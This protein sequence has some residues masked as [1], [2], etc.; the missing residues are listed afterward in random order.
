MKSLILINS[1]QIKKLAIISFLIFVIL[2]I[3]ESIELI[4]DLID[5][6]IIVPMF[7]FAIL[8]GVAEL[9]LW[10]IG[11]NLGETNIV[12]FIF[13][14]IWLGAFISLSF[15]IIFRGCIYTHYFIKKLITEK[16][17]IKK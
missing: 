4:P 2:K 1:G 14:W 15:T 9:V 5:V 8:L 6:I 13:I 16:K 10:Y 7:I 17:N 12:H 3:F 11:L